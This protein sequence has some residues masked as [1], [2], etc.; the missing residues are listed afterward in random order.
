MWSGNGARER[1]V[2]LWRVAES[3]QRERNLRAI[4]QAH[5]KLLAVQRGQC[6]DAALH[7]FARFAPHHAPVLRQT[8]L[9]DIQIGEHLQ[10]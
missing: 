5:D 6:A 7:G 3:F 9:G 8:L 4:E 1:E 2:L 10:A